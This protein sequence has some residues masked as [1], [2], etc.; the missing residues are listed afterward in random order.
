MDLKKT[1]Y[2][3]TENLL[4]K[5]IDDFTLEIKEEDNV[6]H[7]NI[8]SD[9]QASIIIGRYGET[10]KAIQKILEVI[11]YKTLGRF[12]E[13]L[14]NVNDFRER[15]KERLA[16]I[17][18]EAAKRVLEL[19]KSYFIKNLSAYERKIIHQ[20]VTKNYPELKSYS[21]NEGKERK[22]VISLK[23]D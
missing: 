1:I 4:K 18:D 17:L 7:I 20:L 12:V 8:K 22:L 21:I 9:K 2:K 19:K 15:Q 10:I 13:I 3:E 16:K 5:I 11:L 6:F 23:E 14:V